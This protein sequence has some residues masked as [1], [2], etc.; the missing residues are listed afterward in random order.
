MPYLEG[1][2]VP[3]TT[4]GVVA[5]AVPL[6]SIAGRFGLGWLSDVIERRF[7]HAISFVLMAMGTAAFCFMKRPWAVVAFLVF[8]PPGLGG[9][10]VLRSALL[11]QFFGRRSFGKVLGV[12]LGAASIGGVAGPTLAGWGYDVLGNYQVVWVVYCILLALAVVPIMKLKR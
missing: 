3:R 4:A 7:V 5:A 9:S 6:S 1:M 11:R 8:F 2:G 12:T 10:M